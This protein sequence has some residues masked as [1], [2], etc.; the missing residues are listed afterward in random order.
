M[1]WRWDYKERRAQGGPLKVAWVGP[2]LE[3]GLGPEA[4]NLSVV[5]VGSAWEDWSRKESMG[6]GSSRGAA[7]PGLCGARELARAEKPFESPSLPPHPHRRPAPGREGAGPA[8]FKSLACPSLSLSQGRLCTTLERPFSSQGGSD[9]PS[10]PLAHGAQPPAGSPFRRSVS[11]PGVWEAHYHSS[12]FPA[13]QSTQSSGEKERY[14]G[15]ASA[16]R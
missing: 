7:E 6:E 4:P 10:F 2:C 8:N 9:L 14:S 15:G 12:G 11:G 16:E 3:V 5:V 1:R 13:S